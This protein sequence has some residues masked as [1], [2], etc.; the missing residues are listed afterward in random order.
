MDIDIV[1]EQGNLTD[2]SKVNSTYHSAHT[3]V[4]CVFFSSAAPS[5][6]LRILSYDTVRLSEE[7]II[8]S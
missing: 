7:Y 5:S 3:T 2:R 1:E 8:V 6:L 4:V